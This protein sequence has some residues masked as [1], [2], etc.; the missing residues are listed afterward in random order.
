MPCSPPD[1]HGGPSAF[2]CCRASQPSTLNCGPS[3]YGGHGWRPRCRRPS[4]NRTLG[5]ECHETQSMG[6]RAL[7][8]H[9]CVCLC[10]LSSIS[11]SMPPRMPTTRAS[12]VA[13]ESFCN[14][15][16]SLKSVAALNASSRRG[17]RLLRIGPNLRT[18]TRTAR[19]HYAWLPTARAERELN[20][21]GRQSA[22]L[23]E[24]SAGPQLGEY[25]PQRPHVDQLVVGQPQNNLGHSPQ[26]FYNPLVATLE[27]A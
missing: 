21:G 1:A 19:A 2:C 5:S 25:T 8:L 14:K 15:P 4:D 24:H 6:Y 27:S 20:R 18:Y 11:S 3:T 10:A 17:D 9:I 23:E 22:Y 16:D 7:S 26:T 12:S 13:S